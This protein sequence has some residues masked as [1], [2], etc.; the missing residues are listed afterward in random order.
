MTSASGKTP[1]NTVQ[2]VLGTA[3]SLKPIFSYL[4]QPKSWDE[5][6]TLREGIEHAFTFTM[7]RDQFYGG[8]AHCWKDASDGK[9]HLKLTSPNLNDDVTGYKTL[10]PKFVKLLGMAEK[11]VAAG[12]KNQTPAMEKANLRFLPPFGLTLLNSRGVMLLHYPPDEP[13]TYLNYLHARTIKRWD[14]LLIAND[15]E[16]NERPGTNNTLYEA[17]VD[18]FPVTADGGSNGSRLV[19]ELCNPIEG[20]NDY[21]YN[22]LTLLLK[23]KSKTSAKVTLPM[24]ALGSNVRKWMW[25]DKDRQDQ[26]QSQ[27][28]AVKSDKGLKPLTQFNLRL[29]P[30]KEDRTP[31]LMMDHPCKYYRGY[32]E[33][34]AASQVKKDLI[35]A[36]WFMHMAA[37]PAADPQEVLADAK[38]FWG[39]KANRPLLDQIVKC[40]FTEFRNITSATEA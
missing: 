34:G 16:T 19:D 37:D 6:K 38:K 4:K 40:Q 24:V 1:K 11:L 20:L 32:W 26:I 22:L 21:A 8:W 35:G 27:I 2:C 9:Y 15:P 25:R 5:E 12:L 31:V 3:K 39:A 10:V 29:Q 28:G 23:P 13:I 36:R 30:K 14:S 33:R 17:I 7:L 18:L